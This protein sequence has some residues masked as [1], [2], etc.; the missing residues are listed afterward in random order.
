[1][2]CHCVVAVEF[3]IF[4]FT[5]TENF[6][7]CGCC[8][9][10]AY[11]S[12]TI[13]RDRFSWFST[14]ENF[15]LSVRFF[16]YEFFFHCRWKSHCDA[17]TMPISLS[18]P[19]TWRKKIQNTNKFSYDFNLFWHFSLLDC[20]PRLVFAMHSSCTIQ[21][22]TERND[23]ENAAKTYRTFQIVWTIDLCEFVSICSVKTLRIFMVTTTCNVLTENDWKA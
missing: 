5:K 12:F 19:I 3:L 2:K 16:Y 1:M 22:Q 17:N 4:V 8:W 23:R 11:I 9:Y 7:S 10:F 18:I 13:H 15:V 6:F 20:F 21:K 14:L